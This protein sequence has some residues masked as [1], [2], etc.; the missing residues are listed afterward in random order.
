MHDGGVRVA[1]PLTIL[2][3]QMSMRVSLDLEVSSCFQ[4]LH[5]SNFKA[6][7]GHFFPRST[8]QPQQEYPHFPR[9]ETRGMQACVRAGMMAYYGE[10]RVKR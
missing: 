6:G 4:R 5:H 3:S 2:S 8:L 10:Q 1:P 9:L 7:L